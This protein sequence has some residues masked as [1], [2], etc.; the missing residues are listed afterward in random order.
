[1]TAV[2]H[3]DGG[4]SA[5]Y[6]A[7]HPLGV[8]NARSAVYENDA[9]H[10][11]FRFFGN[12]EIR[13]RLC[14]QAAKRQTLVRDRFDARVLARRVHV[15]I[16]FPHRHRLS[17]LGKG[18]GEEIPLRPTEP[19][20][21][22]EITNVVGGDILDLL[23]EIVRRRIVHA[24]H[25]HARFLSGT[26]SVK[27]IIE[28]QNLPRWN[29]EL[30][31]NLFID[32][33]IRFCCSKIVA[34]PDVIKQ[35]PQSDPLC[36]RIKRDMRRSGQNGQLV[37][38]RLQL[39]ECFNDV[40]LYGNAVQILVHHVFRDQA[41][42]VLLRE[43]HTHFDHTL[44]NPVQTERREPFQCLAVA[45]HPLFG[46]NPPHDTAERRHRIH[47]RSV[48]IKKIVSHQQY[49]FPFRNSRLA[50]RDANGSPPIWLVSCSTTAH[51][52][53][54]SSQAARIPSQSS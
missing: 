5:L 50:A 10:F 33:G 51:F 28:E 39:A 25:G 41:E 22:A 42:E 32:V 1:M 48:K 47:E 34:R 15:R 43:V 35:I 4:V 27:I 38:A 29:A 45:G 21:L 49:P 46:K 31:R 6:P 18:C 26:K 13:K 30:F 2:G 24:A 9:G 14:S 12:T 40:L 3:S 23:G 37:S 20:Q 8:G 19:R 36:T 11:A 54:A 17:H 53:P 16:F 7:V 44:G 52:V